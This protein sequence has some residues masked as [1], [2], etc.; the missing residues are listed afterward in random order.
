MQALLAT[1]ADLWPAAS[2]VEVK[3]QRYGRRSHDVGTREF[4]VIPN[5]ESPRILVPR[6]NARAAAGSMRRYSAAI[7]PRETLQRLGLATGLAVGLAHTILPDR[8]RIKQDGTA[9]IIDYLSDFF[10]EPVSIS[11][12]IGPGRANRKPVLQVFDR[13][14][15]SL[16]FV[17]IGDTKA[18]AVHVEREAAS[19]EILGTKTFG[20]IVVPTLL[21]RGIWN[22]MVILIMTALATGPSAR[23]AGF[24]RLKVRGLRELGSSFT[25]GRTALAATPMWASLRA[26]HESLAKGKDRETFAASLTRAE[27]QFGNRQVDV[28]AWHGDF[29]P[30]NM[31]HHGGL[32]HVWDWERFERGVP[33]GMDFLHFTLNRRIRWHGTSADTVMAGLLE[34]APE[35]RERTST[36]ATLAAAY[37]ASITLRYLSGAEGPGGESIDAKSKVML[38]VFD[39]LTTQWNGAG[40]G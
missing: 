34:G 21:H 14:G 18:S 40:H 26:D 30:W 25:E 28:G 2:R 19:L 23:S 24:E 11:I 4:L 31:A 13:R 8:V 38:S 5:A 3:K 36:E 39:R 1:V 12:T 10:S 22:G 32:L 6:E 35:L 33:V 15:H 37:L 7:S 16:A 9:N 27:E 29:S 20:T 17:K